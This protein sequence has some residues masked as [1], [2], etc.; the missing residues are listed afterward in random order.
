MVGQEIIIIFKKFMITSFQV[1]TMKNKQYITLKE[2]EEYA[3]VSRSTLRKW[4]E[5]GMPYYQLGRCV[6][7]KLSEFDQWI[8]QFRAG[9]EK[10]DHLD[11]IWDQVIKEV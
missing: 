9:T 7:V 8:N 1:T 4:K 5:A 11:F 2:L 10:T 3:S 6:R